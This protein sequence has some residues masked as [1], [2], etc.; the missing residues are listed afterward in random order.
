MPVPLV[1]LAAQYQSIKPDI[2]GAIQRILDNTSFILGDEVRAFE[3]AFASYVGA[4]GAVGVSSGTAAIELSLRALG[5]GEW[6]ADCLFAA[7]N[8]LEDLRDC[9]RVFFGPRPTV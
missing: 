4:G 7:T 5:I 2:D 6:D 8:T 9:V 3:S 1:D